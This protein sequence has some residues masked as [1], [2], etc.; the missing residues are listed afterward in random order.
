MRTRRVL[1]PS[2]RSKL[3]STP[4]PLCAT[5]SGC[6]SHRYVA[7]P[8]P[9]KACGFA[10][11][12]SGRASTKVVRAG[13]RRIVR[14]GL[15]RIVRAGLRG[16]LLGQSSVEIFRVELRLTE[17]TPLH[18]EPPLRYALRVFVAPFR[19]SSS[20]AQSFALC[21]LLGYDSVGHLLEQGYAGPAREKLC[22]S[23]LL[24]S[25]P[26]GKPRGGPLT[27]L[28]PPAARLFLTVWPGASNRCPHHKY[29]IIRLRKI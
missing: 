22:S 25:T 28:L 6:S 13:L 3:R 14:A 2:R 8:L 5:R 9:R 29:V 16:H 7:P 23:G 17:Q 4:N 26:R 15:R 1:A 18:S 24:R 21:G 12:F 10:W 20:S 27:M 19:Y 11:C